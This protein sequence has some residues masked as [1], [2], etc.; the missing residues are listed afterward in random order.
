MG[1]SPAMQQQHFAPAQPQPVP[2]QQHPPAPDP[3]LQ[4]QQFA[5]PRGFGLKIPSL[6]DMKLPIERFSGKEMYEGLGAGFKDWGLRFLDELIT[7]QVISGGDW[8]E[9]FK[10]R[11]LNRYFEGPARKYFDRM[12]T[13]WSAEPPTLEHLM[14]RMLEVYEKE[15][16]VEQATRMM[17]ARKLIVSGLSNIRICWQSRVLQT[18]RIVLC[19]STS[20]SVRHLKSRGRCKRGLTVDAPTIYGKRG[21]WR[22]SPARSKRI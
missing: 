10:A 4:Q 14:N 17:R 3:R 16:T 13:I 15:I 19:C 7:A 1:I 20:A 22:T 9:D 5:P 18:V 21:N 6:K 8:P 11:A 12:K 2:F